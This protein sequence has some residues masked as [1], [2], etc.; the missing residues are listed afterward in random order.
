MNFP[1]QISLTLTN[2]CNLNCTMCG[3]WSRQGYVRQRSGD[4]VSSMPPADWKRLVDELAEHAVGAVLLR[5]GEPF[6]F[7]GII[8]LIE[9]IASRNIFIAIDTNGTLLG[10]YAE[11]LI[12]I[13]NLHLTI[14]VDGPESIHDQV[15]GV[16]GCFHKIRE[17]VHRLNELEAKTGRRI[18]KSL[19]F[20]ITPQSLPGLAEMSDVARSL[21]VDTIA[22]V[23]YYYVPEHLGREYDRILQSRFGCTAFSWRGFHHEQSGIDVDFFCRQYRKYLANLKGIRNFPYMDF[24]EDQYRLWFSDP[25]ATVDSP[26][27]GNIETLLDIQP[28]GDA[29]FC[30]DFPDYSFGNLSQSSIEAVWNS[31]AAERFRQYRRKQPL[32]VCHRCGAKYMSQINA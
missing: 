32:P 16:K 3:Q 20:T 9:Y 14:S 18:S 4:S 29:N 5:G 1:Q 24:T 17:G 13:E 23:P 2:A 11:D 8:D 21:S 28:N 10:R 31:P 25:A 19:N 15:R 22:I 30:V 27:C 7:G 26:H 12:K 6:L